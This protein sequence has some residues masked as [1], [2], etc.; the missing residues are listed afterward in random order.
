MYNQRLWG[1]EGRH[2]RLEYKSS[3]QVWKIP[4]TLVDPELKQTWKCWDLLDENWKGILVIAVEA[5]A[6]SCVH[7]PKTHASSCLFRCKDHVCPLSSP[8]IKKQQRHHLLA[9]TQNN[10]HKP[11]VEMESCEWWDLLNLLL[12]CESCCSPVP[13]CSGDTMIHQTS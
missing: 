8:V 12:K 2:W 1:L 7:K 6:V 13:T 5:L 11:A 4:E 3:R 9:W 10:F